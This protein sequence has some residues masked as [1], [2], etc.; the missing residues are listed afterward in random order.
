[1]AIFRVFIQTDISVGY[2]GK[3]ILQTTLTHSF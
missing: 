2:N 3:A 1:M